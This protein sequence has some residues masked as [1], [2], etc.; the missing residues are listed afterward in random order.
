[1]RQKRQTTALILLACFL[2]A[3]GMLCANEKSFKP[4]V[5]AYGEEIFEAERVSEETPTQNNNSSA[6]FESE[7]T[8]EHTP[9]QSQPENTTV[10]DGGAFEGEKVQEEFHT[11]TGNSSNTGTTGTTGNTDNTGNSGS[12]GVTTS[13]PAADPDE[14]GE[15]NPPVDDSAAALGSA[16]DFE[17]ATTSDETPATQPRQTEN[18]TGAASIS[19]V[20]CL[21]VVLLLA[22]AIVLGIV[23]HR[24]KR[25]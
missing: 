9:A 18:A 8:T 11:T 22:A 17:G 24:R 3:A 15:D 4:V 20:F 23:I 25:R 19:P 13:A 10:N 2:V 16:P 12:S 14:P 7:K 5:I 1:M 6:S 21:L